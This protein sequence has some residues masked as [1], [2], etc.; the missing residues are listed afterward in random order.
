MNVTRIEFSILFS[1]NLTK[2]APLSQL[3]VSKQEFHFCRQ[4]AISCNSYSSATSAHQ[5]PSVLIKW[6]C[7]RVVVV[8]MVG[9]ALVSLDLRTF[10]F[11]QF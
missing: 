4:L 7:F 5:Y 3:K 6:R 11:S 8:F 1:R 9:S 10:D 2:Q